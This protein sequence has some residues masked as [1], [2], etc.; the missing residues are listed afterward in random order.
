M[1]YNYEFWKDLDRQGIQSAGQVE[2]YF[3]KMMLKQESN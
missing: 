3:K 2:A 1:K